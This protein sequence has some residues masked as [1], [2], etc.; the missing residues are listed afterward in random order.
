MMEMCQTLMSALIFLIGGSILWMLHREHMSVVA[1]FNGLVKIEEELEED[2]KMNQQDSR[3]MLIKWF[4]KMLVMSG[5]YY[6]VLVPVGAGIAPQFPTN[7]FTIYLWNAELWNYTGWHWLYRVLVLVGNLIV[8]HFLHIC[9]VILCVEL[10]VSLEAFRVLQLSLL[11]YTKISGSQNMWL[12]VK[13]GYDRLRLLVQ[14]FNNVHAKGIIVH[15]LIF[16]AVG[17]VSCLYCVITCVGLPLPILVTLIFIGFDTYI[18]VNGVYG[19]AGEVNGTS[20][21]VRASLKR[22][23]KVAKNNLVQKSMDGLPDLGIK[24]GSV[25]F[26]EVTTPLEFLD[27]TNSRLVDMLLFNR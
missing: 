21:Y 1:V 2:G 10:L 24:F 25:N 14:I 17:Q 4:G 6:A 18:E 13:N 23:S 26:I 3:T 12:K 20:K 11:N 5:K 19:C 15:M 8:W 7:A 9:G 16:L 27:F 22:K